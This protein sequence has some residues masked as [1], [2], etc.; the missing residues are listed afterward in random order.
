[1]FPSAYHDRSLPNLPPG[2]EN[3]LVSVDR[4]E[5]MS[6]IGI[7]FTGYFKKFYFSGAIINKTNT[8]KF[9]MDNY[10]NAQ[11]GLSNPEYGCLALRIDYSELAYKYFETTYEN[12]FEQY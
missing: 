5:K 6:L 2:K 10:Y 11:L 8:R 1:M 7:G 12:Q 9:W 3:L 4:G